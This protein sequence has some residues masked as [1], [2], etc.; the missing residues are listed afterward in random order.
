MENGFKVEDRDYNLYHTSYYEDHDI[1][2]DKIS[3]NVGAPGVDVLRSSAQFMLKSTQMRLEKEIAGNGDLLQYGSMMGDPDYRK[4]V[5]KLLSEEYNDDV[6]WSSL[7]TTSGA[8]AGL[9]LLA[10][11]FFNAGDY[12]FIEDPTY[13]QVNRIVG[14]DLG[15][16]TVPI[17][18]TDDGINL[19]ILTKE[20]EVRRP[21]DFRPTTERPFWALMYAITV[22][23]NPT[24]ICYSKEKCEKLLKLARKNNIMII[25]DDVYNLLCLNK[26]DGDDFERA[27]PRLLQYDVK[28]DED[29]FGNVVSNGSFSKVLGPGLRLG[30]IEAPL[31]V[32]SKLLMNGCLIGG[33]ALN[34]YTSG[35]VA[36]SLN[37]ELFNNYLLMVKNEGKGGY[38]MWFELPSSFDVQAFGDVCKRKHN[39]SFTHGVTCSTAGNWQNCIRICFMYYPVDELVK[40]VRTLLCE[41]DS[42]L[43]AQ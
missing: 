17:P 39:I 33:G 4:N 1:G 26:N 38:F 6:H 31:V 43:N 10:G 32:L 2:D 35:I 15:L 37:T 9:S 42:R 36:C 13:F 8:T 20:I 19:E 18:F 23:Q 41:L 30:W 21:K 5:A 12:I 16:K 11:A 14:I 7:L 22:Y 28:S 40:G 27:P 25:C 29:Y 3:L 34:H 24:G